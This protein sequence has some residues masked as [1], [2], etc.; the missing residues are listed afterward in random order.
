MSEKIVGWLEKLISRRTAFGKVGLAAFGAALGMVGLARPA[1]A[2]RQVHCCT[3]CASDCTPLGCTGCR[4]S[5]CCCDN[6]EQKWECSEC[7]TAGSQCDGSCSNVECSNAFPL[8]AS[9]SCTT[10]PPPAA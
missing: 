1:A 9:A 3:L 5:W 8:P 7:Y 10:C 2:L 4:W 6:H